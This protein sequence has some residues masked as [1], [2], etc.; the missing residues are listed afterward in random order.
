MEGWIKLHRQFINWEWYDDN[1]TKVLFLHLMLTVNHKDKKYRGKLIKRGEII[2]SYD[3][4]ANE[5]HLTVRKIRTSLNK[6]KTTNEIAIK[7][8]SKGTV[9]Q[10]VNYDK[11][12]TETNKTTNERQTNDKQTTTNKNVKNNKNEII[13]EK[14]KK[15]KRFEYVI[16][17]VGKLVNQTQDHLNKNIKLYGKENIKQIT[18][19]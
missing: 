1:N 9:I 11:Y 5:T 19:I 17:G 13:K 2:T 18:E 10:L 4:L 3:K 15:E 8:S 7:T 14:N 12:Q 6:L 16:N